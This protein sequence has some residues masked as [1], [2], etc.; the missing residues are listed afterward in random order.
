MFIL[1]FC[2]NAHETKI[3]V[4]DFYLKEGQ[5][6]HSSTEGKTQITKVNFTSQ[7]TC[8]FTFQDD[9]EINLE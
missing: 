5:V 9:W 1:I 6:K 2:N 4:T 8:Y 3:N 7:V